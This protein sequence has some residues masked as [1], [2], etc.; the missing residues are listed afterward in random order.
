MKVEL[1][2][3]PPHNTPVQ[4][5]EDVWEQPYYPEEFGVRLIKQCDA[6]DNT[7]RKATEWCDSQGFWAISN[8]YYFPSDSERTLFLLN[9]AEQQ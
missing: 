5:E 2:Y 3:L 8:L 7:M 9:W 6:D 4:V 1:F